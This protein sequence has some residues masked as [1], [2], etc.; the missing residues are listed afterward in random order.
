MIYCI[1]NAVFASVTELLVTLFSV[2][3]VVGLHLWKRQTLLS[4]A[5]GTVVYMAALR[6]FL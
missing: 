3:V 5:G 2:G 4:I 1:R 6:I